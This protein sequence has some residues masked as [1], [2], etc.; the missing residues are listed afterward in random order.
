MSIRG[1]ALLG[2]LSFLI[3]SARAAPIDTNQLA[4]SNPPPWLGPG[5]L[6]KTI[7][8]AEKFLEWDIRKVTAQ[9]HPDAAEFKTGHG[10]DSSVLA[11]TRGS[12]HS[13][14]FGPSVGPQNF[15]AVFGHELTH[16]IVFQKYKGAI[17]KWLEEGLANYVGKAA[18]VDYPWLASQPPCDLTT[19]THPFSRIYTPENASSAARYHYMA[20]TAAIEMIASKCDLEQ[21]LQLSVGKDL[22][23]YL[24]TFCSIPDLNAEFRKWLAR[25]AKR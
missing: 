22:T 21:L 19:L 12:D 1:V 17:P 2:A 5:R 11:Y 8:R 14:H 18:R 6:Q 15:D 25:K 20:S 24:G 3:A 23:S 7:D 13:I 9:W 16:V 4:F 10:F